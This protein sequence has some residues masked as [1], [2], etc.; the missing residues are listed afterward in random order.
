[1]FCDPTGLRTYFVNGINNPF[2]SGPPKYAIKFKKELVERGVK[3]VRVFG[4]YNK[5]GVVKG[6]KQVSQEMMN[7]DVYSTKLAER[8][9]SDLEVNPLAKG[10][11]LNLIGYSG[12]GQVVLNAAEKLNGKATINNTVLIGAP[13]AELTLTNM[14]NIINVWAGVDA[15]SWNVG[16][17]EGRYA[18]WFGHTEYFS[19]DNIDNV[20]DIVDKEID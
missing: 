9:L 10:E 1:M 16:L 5:S 14:G 6:V 7:I 11:Q 15:L 2:D 8:I 12:G 13:G 18:G 20:A 4:I 19:N 17:I 3:D